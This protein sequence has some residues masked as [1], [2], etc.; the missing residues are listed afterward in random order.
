[1]KIFAHIFGSNLVHG[2]G[3]GQQLLSA[4]SV[5]ES[6]VTITTSSGGSGRVLR[7]ASTRPI[8]PLGPVAVTPKR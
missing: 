3:Y 1:M 2:A 4:Y 5:V 8:P 7:D 6:V